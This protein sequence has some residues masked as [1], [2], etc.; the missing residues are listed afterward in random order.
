[1][2]KPDEGDADP[3][4]DA[5]LVRVCNEGG[6]DAKRQAMSILWRRHYDYVLRVARRY[7]SDEATAEDAVQDVFEY[8]LRRLA[9][10]GP[11]IQ[12]RAKLTSLLFVVAE[13]AALAA[14]RRMRRCENCGVDPD[15]L[16]APE[17]PDPD[18]FE[19]LIARLTLLLAGFGVMAVMLASVSRRT[20]EIG[21]R[22]AVGAR[23]RDVHWQFLAEA[24]V[25][26]FGG[27]LV[28]VVLGLAT[29]ALLTNVAGAPVAYDA[30]IVPA[31]IGCAVVLGLVF[32][33]LPARR[34]AATNPVAA[35]TAE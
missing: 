30:W 33:I 8:L 17:S 12:A 14:S 29:G 24:A 25:L 22:L 16:P 15:D 9:P 27:G 20:R 1:M 34:A 23:P 2:P 4:S 31:A 10:D 7:A 26:A 19:A 28:G 6:E 11:G 21:L 32:G 35:L 3:R 13:H 5:A 18:G